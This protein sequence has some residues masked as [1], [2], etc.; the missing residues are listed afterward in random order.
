M[1]NEKHYGSSTFLAIK[2]YRLDF[3]L[4]IIL[5]KDQKTRFLAYNFVGS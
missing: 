3:L 5:K 1:T 2:A 4:D